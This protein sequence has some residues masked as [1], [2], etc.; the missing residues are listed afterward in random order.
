MW[1]KEATLQTMVNSRLVE[2]IVSEYTTFEL[3]PQFG[4]LCGEVLRQRTG[5]SK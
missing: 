4:I 3:L 2:S 5:N 1:A